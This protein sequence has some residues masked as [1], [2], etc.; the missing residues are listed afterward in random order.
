MKHKY[1][2][3]FSYNLASK[4][5]LYFINHLKIK[6]VICQIK[7]NFKTSYNYTIDPT[8][9]K[10]KKALFSLEG[11]KGLLYKYEIEVSN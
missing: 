3:Y 6:I 11:V 2:I 9:T 1:K 4:K 8:K 10:L 5:F 7:A